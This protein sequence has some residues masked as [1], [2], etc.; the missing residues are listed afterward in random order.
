MHVRASVTLDGVLQKH[1]RAN[2]VKMDIEGA[3]LDILEANIKFPARIKTLV[4]EYSFSHDVSVKRFKKII[5]LLK[6]QF[7]A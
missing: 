6:S 7:P 4:C 5:K 2:A 3:E 1:T